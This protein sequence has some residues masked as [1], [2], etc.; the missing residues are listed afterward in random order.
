MRTEAM[1]AK[2]WYKDQQQDFLVAQHEKVLKGH[3]QALERAEA[4]EAEV[5]GP[6]LPT[7][8]NKACQVV[9]R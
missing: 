3:Q 9:T 2:S 7:K 1:A 6:S 5:L 4:L 8:I